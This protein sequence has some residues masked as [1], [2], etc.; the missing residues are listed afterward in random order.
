MH[1]VSG[2]SREADRIAPSSA[3]GASPRRFDVSYL[4]V[5]AIVV[6]LSL[7][8]GLFRL[9]EPSL[10]FDEAYSWYNVSRDWSHYWNEVTHGE[11]CGGFV[12]SS[13]VK[14][15]T[16]VVG[17][18]E[19]ALRMPSVLYAVGIGLVLLQIGREL[20][21]LRAGFYMALLGVLHPEVIVWSRQSRAYCCEMFLTS[22]F[23][24]MLLRYARAC[25]RKQ[26]AWL[27]LV[28]SLLALSHIFGIFV[29]AGG[30]LYLLGR[31]LTSTSDG[32][33]GKRLRAVWPTLVP[34]P[35][36]AGWA[37]MLRSRI[38][39]NL[40]S[41]WIRDSLWDSYR[42]LARSFNLLLLCAAICL[43]VGIV[44]VFRKRATAEERLLPAVLGSLAICIAAGPLMVSMLSR[45]G[46][47]FI[48]ARYH[49]P[50]IIVLCVA[51]GY[52][53]ATLPWKPTLVALLAIMAFMLHDRGSVRAFDHLA[54][55]DSDTRAA[56]AYLAAERRPG[57][58][59]LIVPLD[60]RITALYYGIS[61]PTTRTAGDY[62]AK[63]QIPAAVKADPPP[64]PGARKWIMLYR[65]EPED[66]LADF[67]LRGA[68]QTSFGTLRIVRVDAAPAGP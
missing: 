24:L 62:D 33:L 4:A 17:D 20:H 61:G 37:F 50:L 31:Q 19:F 59:V 52:Y 27:A 40:N 7:A 29:V 11:D 12:H 67:G 28:G 58:T 35:L 65:R 10:W 36:L 3:V 44:R 51:V 30:G 49:Y 16:S 23:V 64:Q 26:G 6:G 14:L 46:H 39:N 13:I 54:Y 9:A 1:G 41:F 63:R 25:D 43:V 5:A 60:E 56:A 66:D 22:L 34:V 32:P 47:H 55:D 57:D 68:P 48:I 45:G 21:S 18:G 42:D 2:E 15:W 38:N 8:V 53:A